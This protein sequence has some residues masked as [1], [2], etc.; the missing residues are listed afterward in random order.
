MIVRQA[1]RVL[2]LLV[3]QAASAEVGWVQLSPGCTVRPL[4]A[5]MGGALQI[6]ACGGFGSFLFGGPDLTY[7]G[8]CLTEDEGT[9]APALIPV[10]PPPH[11]SPASPCYQGSCL[12]R[13]A[14]RPWVT[15][16][17][18][19]TAH[20]WS[21]AATVREASDERVDVEL[22]DLAAVGPI[23]P[24]VPSVSDLHVLVQLCAV[25]EAAQSGDRP[26]AVN[27][28]FGRLTMED[29]CESNSN[30]ACTVGRV[31]SYLKNEEG[32]LT[33]A[34]AGNHHEMLFPASAPGVI[35]AGAL[36]LAYLEENHKP[37]ASAQTPPEA[38]ALVLG[39]GLYLSAE[40]GDG[41]A[42]PAPPGSSYSSALFTGWLAGTL[43]GSDGHP[44]LKGERWTPLV[45]AS[46]LTLALDG[47]PLAGSGLE[48]PRRLFER[49]MGTV[50][51]FSEKGGYATLR[52]DGPAPPLPE[53]S[54]L[55]ADNGNGPQPG[56]NPCVPCQGG[57]ELGA[58]NGGEA[59]DASDAVLVDLS[60]SAGLPPDTELVAVLLRVGSELYAFEGSRD[61]DL[62]TAMAAGQ[63]EGIVLDEVGGILVPGEQPSLVL[64]V[65]V[66]GSAY[67]HEVPLNL[68]R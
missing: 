53:L 56:V 51:V 39:Y 48:G 54:V 18:W 13:S 28:S 58:M 2:I 61:P 22:Y 5:E 46:G 37:R 40:G 49:A 57:G 67:W 64:V 24:R 15:V 1:F 14:G 16:L 27:M 42:W 41:P 68:H 60:Y 36:D 25:A 34:A 7:D 45:T 12:G 26:L 63:V 20:G 62:M 32:I 33:V 44:G 9:E 17:D 47:V 29:E 23:A 8:E 38:D 21:V 3:A 4:D 65:N 66:G 19:R 30:L 50:P 59:H 10:E 52:L 11:V 31:L 35:S 43:A 6:V 55:H